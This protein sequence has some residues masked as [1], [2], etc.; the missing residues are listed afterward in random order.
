MPSER[1]SDVKF[2]IGHLWA[3]TYDR[4]V[5]DVFAVESEISQ[6][7]A[8]ALQAKR[9]SR[10]LPIRSATKM[11]REAVKTLRRVLSLLVGYYISI[12]QLKIDPVWDPIRNDPGFKQLLIGKELVGPNR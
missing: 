1:S 7:I 5:K 8:N 4:D 10:Q 12:Q 9:L 11:R 6:E 3:N 2:E